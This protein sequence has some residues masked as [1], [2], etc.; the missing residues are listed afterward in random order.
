VTW[1]EIAR[2]FEIKDFTIKT[3]PP[4]IKKRGDLW[5]DLFKDRQRLPKLKREQ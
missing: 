4:R 3:V 2:G 1:S 5:K